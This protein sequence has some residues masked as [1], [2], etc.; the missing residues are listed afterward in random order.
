VFKVTTLRWAGR[1]AHKK[2]IRNRILVGQ[3]KCYENCIQQLVSWWNTSLSD[4]VH[5]VNG[6]HRCTVIA[7]RYVPIQR[8]YI[9]S[10]CGKSDLLQYWYEMWASPL[11]HPL[12]IVA[13]LITYTNFA[14]NI[15]LFSGTSCE[16]S[17]ITNRRGLARSH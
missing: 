17:W 2:Q 10:N 5:C 16:N 8:P 3:L 9:I 6:P 4:F 12:V 7:V 13:L 14:Q 15:T 11:S 1:V